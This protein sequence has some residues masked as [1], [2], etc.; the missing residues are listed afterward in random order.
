VDN[1]EPKTDQPVRSAP[2][3]SPAHSA[4]EIAE[5]SREMSRRAIIVAAMIGG[6]QLVWNISRAL[7]D[8]NRTEH[9]AAKRERDEQASLWAERYFC[10]INRAAPSEDR[11]VLITGW[12]D[13]YDPMGSVKR[14]E[15]GEWVASKF[16]D[17]FPGDR[18]VQKEDAGEIQ[19][20]DHL[21][22]IASPL[23]NPDA[24]EFA[25]EVGKDGRLQVRVSGRQRN[26]GR[27]IGGYEADLRWKVFTPPGAE[28]LSLLQTRFGSPN[29]VERTEP[30]HAIYDARRPDKPLL[31]HRHRVGRHD[32]LDND[33]AVITV[34]PADTAKTHR[35]ISLAGKHRTGTLGAGQLFAELPYEILQKIHEGLAGHPFFQ[36]LIEIEV[37]NSESH[38]GKAKPRRISLVETPFPLEIRPFT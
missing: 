9:D 10:P 13:V 36:A 35:V 5:K 27:P 1:D 32:R 4:E 16:I 22:L 31:S 8:Q 14:S 26:A 34:L 20:Y 11:V 33:Y 12:K 15:S 23:V 38:K 3:A 24:A 25:G 30:E 6:T 28:E 37:D 2:T 18:V 17:A 19:P 21:V 7:W 29:P